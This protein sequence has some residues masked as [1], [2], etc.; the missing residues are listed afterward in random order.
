MNAEDPADR[1]EPV[2][3]EPTV[4]VTA[5]DRPHP[6]LLAYY[7]LFSLVAGPFFPLLLVPLVF[8]YRTLRYEFGANEVSVRWGT[9]WRRETSLSYER[10]QDIHLTRN[11]FERWL[12]LARVQV[13]TA[14]GS[15][16]PEM[17]IEGL[18]PYE[19]V[20]SFLSER[21]RG[22]RHGTASSSEV[23]GSDLTAVVRSLDATTEALRSLRR[24]LEQAPAEG[25]GE[26]HG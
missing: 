21:M 12:G 15:H 3:A 14:S 13:Q 7:A 5:L 4:D 22:A 2:P 24:R 16:K 17:T 20:R 19:A 26:R 9:V 18:L 23:A 25:V 6:W 1:S 11:L 10:I 8:R